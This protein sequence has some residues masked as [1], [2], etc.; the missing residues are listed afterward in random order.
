MDEKFKKMHELLSTEYQWP[1]PYVFKFIAP[2]DKVGSVS[3]LFD[4]RFETTNKPSK[5]GNYISLTAVGE[6][7]SPDEVIKIYQAAGSIPG[8]ISL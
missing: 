7:S 8:V 3:S 1:G 5:K 2:V 6:M 4:E